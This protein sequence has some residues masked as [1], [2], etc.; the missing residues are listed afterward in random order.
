MGPDSPSSEEIRRFEEQY[1]RQP[2]SLVFARLADAY[3]KAGQPEKAL[4]ILEEGLMRHPDYPSGHIVRARA[5]RDMGKMAETLESFRRVLELDGANLVAIRELAGL[6]DERGDTGEARH[7]YERL[8]QIDPA[9]L[10]VRQRLRD[11]DAAAAEAVGIESVEAESV[12]RA[13]DRTESGE[14]AD[15]EEG[16]S[17]WWDDSAVNVPAPDFEAASD[18]ADAADELRR[19]ED[20]AVEAILNGDV[21]QTVRAEDTWWYE[22]APQGE[23]PE[24]SADADLLTRTMADLYA[25]QG[26]RREAAEIYEELL[27]DSPGDPELLTRLE[28]LREDDREASWVAE[29]AETATPDGD[30]ESADEVDSADEPI[31]QAADD[32]PIPLGRP[33]GTPWPE[34]LR[35]LLR[36]GEEWSG[37]LPD[38]DM[39]ALEVAE[40][41]HEVAGQVVDDDAGNEV[42]EPENSGP[43]GFAREWIARLEADG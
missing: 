20:D 29:V 19:P 24:P 39:A 28:A 25:E 17:A 5:L 35:R 41:E 22:E 27:K 32:E 6:A 42:P 26:L 31:V 1:R 38:R 2:E 15:V 18:A 40:P 36:L 14:T 3:R 12:A 10:E 13:P 30:A 9:D 7:W 11:L 43:S 23:E 37:A 34:E 21:P 8:G 16:P 33:V 4:A